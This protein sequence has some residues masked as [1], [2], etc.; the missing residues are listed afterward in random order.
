MTG[1][2]V[3]LREAQDWEQHA[4]DRVKL[5]TPLQEVAKLVAS[6]RKLELESWPHL[7][8]ARKA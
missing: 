5:G 8:S 2:E 7:I 6:W 3:L 1:M 4:S